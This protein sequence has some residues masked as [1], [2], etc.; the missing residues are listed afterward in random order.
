MTI[1]DPP[2]L[3]S[4]PLPSP[5]R[6]SSGFIALYTLAYFSTVLLFLAPVLVTL[7][8]KI[9][10]LVGIDEAPA[11][12]ALV[13]GVGALLA[14]FANPFF[15]MLS[16]RTTSRFGARRPW[17]VVGL[18]VGSLGIFTVAVAPNVATVLLG[19]CIAQVFFNALMASL[20]AV[21]ADQVPVVQRGTV[22]GVLGVCVPV[23]S[24]G[25]A[26][27]VNLFAG[28]ELSMF[29]APCAIGGFFI[30]LFVFFLKDRQ[31]EVES[32]PPWSLRTAL[33][34]F[35][36]NP[37]KN[38]DFAWAFAS[39]F[40]FVLA[41]GLLFTFLVYFLIDELG[42]AESDVP[43]Q[44]LLGVLVQSGVAVVA[45]II[46]GRL[47]DH[48]R[49]RKVFVVTAAFVYSAGMFTLAFAG[50][51]NGFLLAMGIGGLGFGLYMAVDLAL[52]VEVLPSGDQVA[53]DLGV[54]NIAAALPSSIA[55]AI[56]PLI[57][58]VSSGS[59]ALL[60]VVAGVCAILAAVAILP[61]RR[62]R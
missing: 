28:N 5:A 51:L 43:G 31:R 49:R 47:S 6:V 32:R 48:F 29:L 60:Y 7:A 22:A 13:A 62:V 16:D 36:V 19:W 40:L 57:L 44:I 8:L 52:V 53:K 11:N 23:A 9:N 25:G 20:A 55:P 37:R 34:I 3:D 33:G 18:G 21:L 54:L 56:A 50:D 58:A 15:G 35:Y 46:G 26:A 1:S 24:V 39:R 14:M 45:S 10:T 30:L 61:I 27:L 38:P 2:V 41:Y 17:M 59:Y 42:S 12:L 4:S